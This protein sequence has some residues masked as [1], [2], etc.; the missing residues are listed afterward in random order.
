MRPGTGSCLTCECCPV[1]LREPAALRQPPQQQPPLLLQG[2]VSSSPKSA[3]PSAAGL[4]AK[5]GFA[6]KFAAE[7]AKDTGYDFVTAPNKFE[8]LAAH[9]AVVHM[10]GALNTAAVSLY[11]I[12][13][14]MR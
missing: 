3:G 4:N 5:Q 14:D 6:E 10:S 13:N 11:K 1:S 8:G 12:A 7:V 2:S 9:D